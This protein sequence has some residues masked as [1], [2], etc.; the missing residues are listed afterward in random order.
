MKLSSYRSDHNLS[1][2]INVPRNIAQDAAITHFILPSDIEL[3][4]SENLV[5]KFLH[6]IAFD[7]RTLIRNRVYV[8]PTFEVTANS[9]PPTTKQQLVHMLYNQTAV[10]FHVRFCEH[11]SK[12]PMIW[13]WKE[14]ADTNGKGESTWPGNPQL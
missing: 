12:V 10:E 2:Y 3:Y 1:F 7:E 13:K 8:I 6:M 9:K 11:C 14:I 5:L 4:P